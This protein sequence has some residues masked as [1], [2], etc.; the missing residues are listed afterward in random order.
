MMAATVSLY[1]VLAASVGTIHA[2]HASRQVECSDCGAD[3]A[4]VE[5]QVVKLR[6]A[7]HWIARRKAARALRSY[8]WK[9]HPDAV[10]ALS[11]AVRRD[12]QCLVRQEA[13]ESLGKMKPCLP[14]AHEALSCAAKGD[15]S[16]IARLAAKKALKS[17]GKGC[18]EPCDVCGPEMD[19]DVEFLPTIHRELG[20]PIEPTF[21][22]L[23]PDAPGSLLEPLAPTSTVVP[24]PVP[25]APSP[26]LPVP[27][28]PIPA[29]PPVGLPR[30][31][32][33]DALPLSPPEVPIDRY[34]PNPAEPPPVP[35]GREA[36]PP[37]AEWPR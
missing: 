15:S 2:G 20:T 27:E 12:R 14:V 36:F 3:F 9:Q 1:V 10:E 6:T 18:V 28:S 31:H 19:G 23:V 24:V 13:A 29:R 33:E 32:P 25:P 16:L 8:D 22:E 30:S 21:P 4:A 35:L 37:R 34:N 26:F 5:E 7:P 17:V 11:E